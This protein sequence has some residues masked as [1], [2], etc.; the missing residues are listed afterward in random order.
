MQDWGIVRC[1]WTQFN[2]PSMADTWGATC[3]VRASSDSTQPT[4]SISEQALSLASVMR[5]HPAGHPRESS[6]RT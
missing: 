2:A 5:S 1:P 3:T 4:L 6:Q